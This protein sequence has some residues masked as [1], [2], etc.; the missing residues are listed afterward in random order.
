MNIKWIGFLVF[1]AAVSSC[2]LLPAEEGV[3]MKPGVAGNLVK[4]GNAGLL[5]DAG[6]S[7]AGGGGS[8]TNLTLTAVANGTNFIVTV[9]FDATNNVFRFTKEEDAE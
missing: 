9:W 3:Q 7:S 1:C 8:A 4:I 5:V 6:V 2:T